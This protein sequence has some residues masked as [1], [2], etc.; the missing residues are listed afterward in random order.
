MVALS[1]GRHRMREEMKIQKTLIAAT[2]LGLALSS[3]CWADT[4]MLRDGSQ[5]NGTFVGATANTVSMKDASGVVHRYSTSRISS[6]QFTSSAAAN[7]G[8]SSRNNRNSSN[9]RSN[10]NNNQVRETVPVGTQLFIRTN[11][12]IDS[13]VAST[14]QTFSAQ[15]DQDV[16]GASSGRIVIPRGS[17][18]QLV[19]RSVSTGSM[20]GG[21]DMV[22]DVQ[23]I[24]VNGR[25]YQIST[26]DLD[27]KSNTG[28][29]KNKRT[30]EM[31][32]GGAALGAIIGAV[33]GHGKGAAIGA[34][35]G[36]AGGAGTQVLLKG[37]HVTVPSE[38]ILTFT[39]NQAVSI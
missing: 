23:A 19:I 28:I 22:L 7:N 1:C 6:V 24:T 5:I 9:N 10:A 3:T 33:V 30:A 20:T 37:K 35:A 32:G 2:S 16:I 4:L 15:F 11:D 36:A 31:V 17:N 18:A 39:L 29:G 26:A 34:A 13:S 21:A 12:A 14:N 8:F 25:S 27:E 38:S